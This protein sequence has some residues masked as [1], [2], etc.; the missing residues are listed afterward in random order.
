[1]RFDFL[2]LFF[3][4]ALLAMPVLGEIYYI[5]KRV[6]HEINGFFEYLDSET[7]FRDFKYLKENEKLTKH[8]PFD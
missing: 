2:S 3:I 8:L 5:V 6:T 4:I 1:M 7:N